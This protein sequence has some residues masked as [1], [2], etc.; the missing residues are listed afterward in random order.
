MD[1]N[2]KWAKPDRVAVC[3]GRLA[4]HAL[5]AGHGSVLAAFPSA[6]Y[7]E[8]AAGIACLVPPPAPRGPLN[9]VLHGFKPRMPERSG[10][11]WRADAATLAIDGFGTFPLPAHDEWTPL[12]FP[13]P[14]PVV[15]VAGLA[16]M[17]AAL[18]VRTPHG[19]VLVHAL[20]PLSERPA[21]A[22]PRTLSRTASRP[23]SMDTH[24]ARMVPALSEWLGDALAGGHASTPA[25]VADLLGA[26]HGLTP[27]GDD[28]IV[29]VLV[30]LHALGE[31]GVAASVARVVAR[32]AP[33]RT[34]RVSAAH[35]DAACAGEASEPVHAAIEAIAGRASPGPALDALQKYGH[36]SGFDALAG[37]LVAASAIA[38]TAQPP[39]TSAGSAETGPTP[40]QMPP[41]HRT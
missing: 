40:W 26:G 15:L 6:L 10:A 9:V 25:P 4:R 12:R 7:L 36:G 19:A 28:C 13:A 41:V 22:A 8:S 31:R 21:V 23:G 34:S 37:V 16:S 24:F 27:S 35:L 20:R 17:R 3:M 1:R 18:A 2:P 5:M 14:N 38:H 29:G 11:T 30:A 32:Y 39:R 33:H